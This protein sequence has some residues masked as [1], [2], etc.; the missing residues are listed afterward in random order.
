MPGHQHE[1]AR[2]YRARLP[3][4]RR[5]GIFIEIRGEARTVAEW[6]T[7]LGLSPGSIMN[8][9]SR[10]WCPGCAVEL[11]INEKFRSRS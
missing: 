11:P 9:L 6:G 3:G 2:K 4:T 10:G 7:R 8:R 5:I 1:T